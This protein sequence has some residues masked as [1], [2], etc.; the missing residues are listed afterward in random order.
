MRIERNVVSCYIF[1]SPES[2]KEHFVRT[3]AGERDAATADEEQFIIRG[4]G[5]VPDRDTTKYLFVRGG[6]TWSWDC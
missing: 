2:G 5:A 1:G 3:F 6:C 4:I